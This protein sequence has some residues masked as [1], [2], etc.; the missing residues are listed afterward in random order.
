MRTYSLLSS[1]QPKNIAEVSEDESWIKAIEEEL[2]QIK[3]YKTWEL[4]QK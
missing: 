1:I 4:D 3:K 2:N